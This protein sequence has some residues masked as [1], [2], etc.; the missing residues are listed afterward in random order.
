V[1]QGINRFGAVLILIALPLTP[2]AQQPAKT[3]RIGFLGG[4]SRSRDF[5]AFRQG[6][7]DLGWLE[8]KGLVI[9]PRYAEGHVDRLAGLAAEL[10]DLHVDVIVAS[11]STVAQAAKQATRTIPI[12][13]IGVGD[14]VGLG[15][16]ASLSRPGGNMTGLASLLPELAAK[17]LQLLKEVVPRARRI[18]VLTNPSNPL[19]EPGF[20]KDAEPAA[21]VLGVQLQL[22]M[23]RGP[24]D[25]EGALEAAVKAHADALEIY[26]DPVFATY[27]SRLAALAI[28]K[29]L[30]TMFRGKQDVEAG[31]LLGYGPSYLDLSRR[32][33]TFVDKILKGAEPAD[34]PIEQPT[35]F[36]L[37]INLKSAKA[38]GLTIPQ[39]VLARADEVIQ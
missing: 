31:G 5:E 7:R 21:K 10:V 32:A 22:L 15:F 4:G 14:P 38:L 20:R 3:Y 13:M 29:R 2:M 16:A 18:A 34:L 25:F 39:P 30:P 27:R 12:V 24:D 11:T 9:E 28:E 19:H 37:V 36:E 6:L 26:G 17:S 35:K 8:G 23:A 1:F 33:A